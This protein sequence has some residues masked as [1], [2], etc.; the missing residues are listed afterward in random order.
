LTFAHVKLQKQTWRS[1]ARL[2]NREFY[3]KTNPKRTTT[4]SWSSVTLASSSATMRKPPTLT[5]ANISFPGWGTR[6]SKLIG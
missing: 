6:S 1:G 5:K 3:A 2:P 4:T